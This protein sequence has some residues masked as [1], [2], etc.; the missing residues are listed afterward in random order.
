[1]RGPSGTDGTLIFDAEGGVQLEVVESNASRERNIVALR[2]SYIHLAPM[3]GSRNAVP[4]RIHRRM[5]HGDFIQYVV[6]WPAGQLIVRRPP[7]EML[8]EGSDVTVSFA[9]VHCVLL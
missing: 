2:T 1:V 4:G 8:D 7:T 5:F 3:P 9:P 6:D